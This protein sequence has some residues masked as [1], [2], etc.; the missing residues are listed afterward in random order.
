MPSTVPRYMPTGG[1]KEGTRNAITHMRQESAGSSVRAIRFSESYLQF[2]GLFGDAVI[3]ECYAVLFGGIP[4]A[5]NE[6]K[7]K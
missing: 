2:W 5:T 3:V 4:G 6:E 7:D 1:W